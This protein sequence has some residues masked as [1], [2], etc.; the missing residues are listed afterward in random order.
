[1]LG[2]VVRHGPPKDAGPARHERGADGL[3]WDM[4]GMRLAARFLNL[5]G[6]GIEEGDARRLEVLDVAGDDG[7]SVLEGGGGDE[8]V[9]ALV[10]EG[11]A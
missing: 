7:E 11:P 5:V 4:G 10:A 9:E 2:A 3:D 8:E 6:E 1:M